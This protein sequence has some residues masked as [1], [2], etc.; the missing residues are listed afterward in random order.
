[1]TPA[2]TLRVFLT[3]ISVMFKTRVLSPFLL[4]L[5]IRRDHQS[6]QDG[7]R[8]RKFSPTFFLTLAGEVRGYFISQS[9]ATAPEKE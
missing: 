4:L 7:P 8:S 6:L 9:K 3:G 2:E 1:M 5:L